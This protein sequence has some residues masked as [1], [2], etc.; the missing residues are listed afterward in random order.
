MIAIH[1]AAARRKFILLAILPLL[2]PLL[3]G[4]G[5]YEDYKSHKELLQIAA[6]LEARHRKLVDAGDTLAAAA[7][8]DSIRVIEGQVLYSSTR[9]KM[10]DQTAKDFVLSDTNGIPVRLSNYRGKVVVID[11]WASWCGP[12]IVAFPGLQR[13]LADSDP[14]D[15]H[16]L[17]INTME[18]APDQLTRAK[19]FMESKGYYDFHVLADPGSDVARTYRVEG[20]PTTIVIGADGKIKFRKTGTSANQQT[21]QKELKTMIAVSGGR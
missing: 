13:V 11:F 15:V 19:A 21:A 8:V 1:S 16:F 10:L 5:M 7:V 3:S 12:C 18:D 6:E 4:C 9:R 14:A 20:L 17:F 2:L